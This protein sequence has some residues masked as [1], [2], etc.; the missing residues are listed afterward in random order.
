VVR[1]LLSVVMVA[2][3]LVPTIAQARIG[4][5]GPRAAIAVA[6]MAPILVA[7]VQPVVPVAPVAPVMVAPPAIQVVPVASVTTLR[8]GFF[9]RRLIPRTGYVYG[10]PVTYVPQ[11]QQQQRPITPDT[12]SNP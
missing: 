12:P 6:P 4:C 3:T 8:W 1:F 7:P 5:C 10:A 2:A 9:H 11:Q